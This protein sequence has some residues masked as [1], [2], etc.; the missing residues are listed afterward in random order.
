LADDRDD[1]H[2][3]EQDNNILDPD[4]DDHLPEDDYD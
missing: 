3:L 4:D 1:L 2:V